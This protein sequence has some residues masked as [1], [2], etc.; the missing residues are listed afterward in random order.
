MIHNCFL[1]P[2][3]HIFDILLIFWALCETFYKSVYPKL[4]SKSKIAAGL[5][6]NPE[7]ITSWNV[8]FFHHSWCWNEWL[9]IILW[10]CWCDS[11][12][13]ATN[14]LVQPESF[15]IWQ[16]RNSRWLRKPKSA[17]WR[18]RRFQRDWLSPTS[19]FSRLT[20]SFPPTR[21][22]FIIY[23]MGMWSSSAVG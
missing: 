10:S 3:F 4:T 14:F 11:R 20:V 17:S 13:T 12:Y 21:D 6:I 5:P 1:S 9:N 2:N 15:V 23:L 19:F 7:R 18:W 16:L 22:C 8:R